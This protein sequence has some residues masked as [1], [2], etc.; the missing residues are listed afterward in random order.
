MWHCTNENPGKWTN[1][2][3][4]SLHAHYW[5]SSNPPYPIHPLPFLGS[6]LLIL[7]SHVFFI[8]P[9]LCISTHYCV[10][11]CTLGLE[12]VGFAITLQLKVLAVRRGLLKRGW[13]HKNLGIFFEFL[14]NVRILSGSPTNEKSNGFHR[15]LIIFLFSL[16]FQQ[17]MQEFSA[18]IQAKWS[19]FVNFVR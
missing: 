2:W 7:F 3:K 11:I 4:Q 14:K 5:S 16:L 13:N 19:Y 15:K 17:I 6:L 9:L 18:F 10:V 12:I 1:P 8:L